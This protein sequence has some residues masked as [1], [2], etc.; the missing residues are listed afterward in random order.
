MKNRLDLQHSAP[1]KGLRCR[2][3]LLTSA[4]R[5][6]DGLDSDPMRRTTVQEK[7]LSFLDGCLTLWIFLSTAEGVSVGHFVPNLAAF[8]NRFKIG[9]TNVPIAIGLTA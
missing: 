6:A 8:V 9:T 7:K 2:L 5:L 4:V 3:L 1:S